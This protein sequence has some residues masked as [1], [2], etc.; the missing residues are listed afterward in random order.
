MSVLCIK[1]AINAVLGQA[2]PDGFIP[3]G[4]YSFFLLIYGWSRLK[5]RDVWRTGAGD[6]LCIWVDSRACQDG[7]HDGAA[8]CRL[9]HSE[10]WR[11]L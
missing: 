5:G 7:V 3:L 1:K 8:V 6:R 10:T 11:A 9:F 2:G 4:V